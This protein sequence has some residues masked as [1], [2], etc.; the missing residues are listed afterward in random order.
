MVPFC[1]FTLC[2][3]ML[4]VPTALIS[5]AMG[6]NRGPRET[7]RF[8]RFEKITECPSNLR[9]HRPLE[10]WHLRRRIESIDAAPQCSSRWISGSLFY[11][12]IQDQ[13]ANGEG[14]T[15]SD[16]CRATEA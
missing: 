10:K 1:M 6:K 13:S 3:L 11:F 5:R 14:I 7:C 4:Y 12:C 16:K 8:V 9:Q 15:K 2:D